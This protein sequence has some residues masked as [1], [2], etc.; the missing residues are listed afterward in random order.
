MSALRIGGPSDQL[1]P[2]ERTY[3]LESTPCPSGPQVRE[4]VS[5][6]LAQKYFLD[7]TFGGAVITGQRNVLTTTADFTG[8]AFLFEPRH[9]SPLISRLRVQTTANTD[10]EWDLDYDFQS[11]GV[12]SSTA[13][14]NYRLG[15]FT[16]GGGDAY[17]RAP[18][19]V[20]RTTG[21]PGEFNQ[22]RVLFGYGHPNKRGFSG[23]TSVG[24]DANIGFL[25][26][27]TVQTSYNW[28]CCGVSIEYRR[29]ALG[30]VRNENQYR[31]NFTL[32]NIGSVG[33]IRKQERLY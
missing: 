28:D 13:L 19:N 10:A 20:A 22:F 2:W 32:A 12:N 27:A 3:R 31:F 8:T 6:T 33:N 9:L 23:A 5:W 17:V 7:P 11:G 29:F 21:S 4:L 25:Q 15:L 24:Y 1:Q 16:F 18:A 30:S 26:Y 14:F